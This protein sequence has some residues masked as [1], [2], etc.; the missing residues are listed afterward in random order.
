MSARGIRF[1]LLRR[2]RAFSTPGRE[3][4][5]TSFRRLLRRRN[6]RIPLSQPMVGRSYLTSF[7]RLLPLAIYESSF[8]T[9]SRELAAEKKIGTGEAP[10]FLFNI[11]SDYLISAPTTLYSLPSRMISNCPLRRIF[12]ALGASSTFW[13]APGTL[14]VLNSLITIGSLPIQIT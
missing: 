13:I 4:S 5:S 1:L 7:E 11:V 14:P 3:F 9:H 10:I 8:S 12:V 6:L 2:Q